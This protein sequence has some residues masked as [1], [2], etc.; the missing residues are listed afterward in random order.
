MPLVQVISEID[1]KR[2]QLVGGHDGAHCCLEFAFRVE[3]LELG[4][5]G[6]EIEAGQC[7]GVRADPFVGQRPVRIESLVGV[8]RE[9]I[10]NQILGIFRYLSPVF[11]VKLVLSLSDL[12]EES[13]LIRFDKRWISSQ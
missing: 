11:F 3:L 9:Q 1:T 8:Y 6:S 12:T 5:I 13:S 2:V 7:F 4:E 10:A